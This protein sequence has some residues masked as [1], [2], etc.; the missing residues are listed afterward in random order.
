MNSLKTDR[1]F[2]FP[3]K[4]ITIAKV[5]VRPT[6]YSSLLINK[7]LKEQND[8]NDESLILDI[9][10]IQTAKL[11]HVAYKRNLKSKRITIMEVVSA[12]SQKCCV[13]AI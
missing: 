9:N 13:F 11:F 12:N 7:K 1:L 10:G 8:H 6:N 2:H 5:C 3:Y 4:Q